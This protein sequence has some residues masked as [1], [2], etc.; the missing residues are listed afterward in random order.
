[1]LSLLG[2]IRVARVDEEEGGW[3]MKTDTDSE[4]SSSLLIDPGSNPAD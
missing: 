4:T 3:R 1:M 2:L